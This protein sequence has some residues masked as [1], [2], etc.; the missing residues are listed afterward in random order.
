MANVKKNTDYLQT[1]NNLQQYDLVSVFKDAETRT[2][3]HTNVATLALVQSVDEDNEYV[4]CIPYPIRQGE[5]ATSIK[6]WNMFH[7]EDIKKGDSILVIFTDR[8]YRVNVNNVSES[9]IVQ[10][11]DSA[12]H[13]MEYGII[14][15]GVG[16]S[17]TSSEEIDNLKN[18]IASMQT[19]INNMQN[20][21]N[22]INNKIPDFDILLSY[23]ENN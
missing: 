11:N 8:D 10:T 1:R 4:Y 18:E 5:K 6:V 20:Q 21:I 13:K 16:R 17:E 12:L 23:T 3:R 9:N 7:I 14:I 15:G 19:T 2:M 22:E